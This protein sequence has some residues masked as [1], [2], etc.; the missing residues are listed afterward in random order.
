MTTPPI[1]ARNVSR[2]YERGSEIV[3]AVD[4]V[5]V[6]LEAGVLYLLQGP[7]GS[8]K[9]TLLNMLAG[10]ESPDS[11]RIEWH[12]EPADPAQLPW[13]QLAVV[14]QRVGLLPELT[15]EENVTLSYRAKGYHHHDVDDLFDALDL[16][17]LHD[18]LPEELSAGQQQRVS[19]ARALAAVPTVMLVDEPTS[20]QD[21]ESARTVLAE[22]RAATRDGRVCFVASHD[23]I[24]IEYAD[25]VF[26]MRDGRISQP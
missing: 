24:A 1:A 17:D 6:E 4:D 7:S 8:G 5:T 12:G 23:P 18:A 10:W 22:L 25:V 14:P 19:I 21:E 15:A 9:T 2:R 11:G 13:T 20:S 26:V 16:T 3:V